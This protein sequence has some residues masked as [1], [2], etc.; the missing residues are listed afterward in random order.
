LDS[1][2]KKHILADLL[3]ESDQNVALYFLALSLDIIKTIRAD[4]ASKE[5]SIYLEKDT[6]SS[7]ENAVM[8]I[9]CFH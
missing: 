8:R 2:V 1:K 4:Q 9:I 5:N 7:A 6:I 3:C